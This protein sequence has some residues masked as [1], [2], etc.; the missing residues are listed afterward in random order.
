MTLQ[1]TLG[2]AKDKRSSF[3]NYFGD[4]NA[5]NSVVLP[6]QNF[7]QLKTQKIC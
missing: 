3:I 2:S 6:L 7:P 5:Y 4:S 1:I